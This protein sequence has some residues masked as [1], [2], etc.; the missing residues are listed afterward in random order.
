M[1]YAAGLTDAQLGQPQIGISSMG[2]DGNPCNS[3]L[4]ALAKHVQDGCALEGLVGLKHSTVGVSDGQ[5]QGNAGM[6]YSLPSRDLIADSIELVS[7]CDVAFDVRSCLHAV[8]RARSY[9]ITLL[10]RH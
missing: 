2:F 7:R 6:R 9:L 5:T 10:P 4:D 1:L 3:H 8:T